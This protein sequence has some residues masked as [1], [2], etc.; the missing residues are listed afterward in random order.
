MPP[1]SKK[2]AKGKGAASTAAEDEDFD[3]LCSQLNQ[4]DT[5]GREAPKVD[6]IAERNRALKEARRK[7]MSG[8]YDEGADAALAA[9]P[10]RPPASVDTVP[11]D[12]LEAA[13]RTCE[14]PALKPFLSNLLAAKRNWISA[15]PLLDAA[16]EDHKAFIEAIQAGQQYHLPSKELVAAFRLAAEAFRQ[17]PLLASLQSVS[18]TASQKLFSVSSFFIFE[19]SGFASRNKADDLPKPRFDGE[20]T[21]TAELF[22]AESLVDALFVQAH[23]F[24]KLR[25]PAKAAAVIPDGEAKLAQPLALAK[26]GFLLEAAATTEEDGDDGEKEKKKRALSS[27]ASALLSSAS[28]SA[29]RGSS[30]S[31]SSEAQYLT[32]LCHRYSTAAGDGANKEAEVD[33]LKA[34][35]SSAASSAPA[36]SCSSGHVVPALFRLAFVEAPSAESGKN[37]ERA[38]QLA[39][40]LPAFLQPVLGAASKVAKEAASTTAVVAAAS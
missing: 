34:F 2:A 22:Y 19:D 33:A 1:K 25:G 36:A 10:P 38:T 6:L 13:S 18:P 17:E 35:L 32:S 26:A 40:S 5:T 7:M 30:S 31:S 24:A 4:I 28:A 39:R 14:E 9:A 3:A 29:T 16:D 20:K 8:A 37:Y 21:T 12:E 15:L 11:L 27:D 23:L